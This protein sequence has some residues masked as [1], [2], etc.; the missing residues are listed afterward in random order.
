MSRGFHNF[1]YC[2]E[3]DHEWENV[4]SHK[5]VERCPICTRLLEPYDSEVATD[6]DIDDS[7][8]ELNLEMDYDYEEDEDDETA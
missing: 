4:R 3:C 6:D 7:S 5:P 2:R 1:Y 8:D